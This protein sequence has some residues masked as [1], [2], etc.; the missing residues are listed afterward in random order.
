[1]KQQSSQSVMQIAL[2]AFVALVMAGCTAIQPATTQ[3]VATPEATASPAGATTTDDSA[4]NAEFD[5]MFIDMMVP[6]H[7]SASAMAQIALDRAEHPEVKE[8]AQQIIDAQ[9]AEIEQMRTWRQEWYGSSDTPPMS[10]MPMLPGMTMTMTNMMGMTDTMAMTGSM[11]MTG[12]MEMTGTMGM[13]NTMDMTQQAEQLRNAPEPFDK[14]FIEAMIPHHQSAI[15]AAR[16]AEQQATHPEIKELAGKMI[17][18]QQREID[19]LQTWR[20]E[21]YGSAGM[22]PTQL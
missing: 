5:R 15:E 3:P 13:M 21:W 10:Q 6:H 19:Q 9:N 1:M 2:I 17:E 12:T 11:G 4:M 18:E 7:Q 14:A 16:L 8:M 22:A 20:Q